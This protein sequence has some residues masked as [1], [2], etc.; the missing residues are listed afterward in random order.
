MMK[1]KL[2]CITYGG[3]YLGGVAFA[4]ARSEDE[5][6]DIVAKDPRTINFSN[7]TFSEIKVPS[8]SPFVIYNDS[9]EY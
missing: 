8:A 1:R 9:G 6:L 3:S 4:Y 5:A 2:F 7:Y